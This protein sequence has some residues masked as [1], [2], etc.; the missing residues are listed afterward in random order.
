MITEKYK[1]AHFAT[2]P[3][4]LAERCIKAGSRVGDTVLDPFV[5]SGT[6]S[7]VAAKLGRK[8]VGID[9]SKKFIEIA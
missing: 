4:V 8:S 5:G 6:T 7:A 9:I 2:F 3:E 1:G